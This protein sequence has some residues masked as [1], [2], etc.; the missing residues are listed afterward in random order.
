MS[1]GRTWPWVV[2]RITFRM[3]MVESQG[4]DSD[5][6]ADSNLLSRWA[7]MM[8]TPMLERMRDSGGE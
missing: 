8:E 7:S 4:G 3:T 5:S 1:R 6:M 2:E